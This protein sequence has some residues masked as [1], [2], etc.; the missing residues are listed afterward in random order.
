MLSFGGFLRQLVAQLQTHQIIPCVLRNYEGFP[1]TN[2]GNDVDFMIRPDQLPFAIQAVESIPG[3][4]IT[5]YNE[6]YHVAMTFLDGVSAV[7]GRNAFQVDFIRS[8]TWKGLP[9]LVPEDVIASAVQRNQDGFKF[10]VPSPVCEALISL[11]TSLVI[12][13]FVKERYFADVRRELAS[14]PAEAKAILR[15]AF[16][17]RVAARL[18]EATIDGDK[19]KILLCIGP[20]RR[21]L[22]IRRFLRK[23]LESLLAVI[24]HHAIVLRVRHS[25]QT[26][27]TI[28]I[29]CP[30]ARL[31][32][33]AADNLVA[34]LRYIAPEVE[35]G[36]G[37]DISSSFSIARIAC[38]LSA[39]WRRQFGGRKNL[40]LRVSSSE[41]LYQCGNA[42]GLKPAMHR[43]A[44]SLAVRFLPRTDL[45]IL[46]KPHTQ[47]DSLAICGEWMRSKKNCIEVDASDPASD[48]VA[49]M[50]VAVV[51]ALA[52][53]T[54]V[55]LVSILKRALLAKGI[56]SRESEL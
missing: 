28:R 40:T 46:L 32:K 42:K 8:F 25:P 33:Q 6:Q 51:D 53:R 19:S 16:G 37:L 22:L 38:W 47:T 4:R 11:L 44:A 20:L 30:N 21:A 1:E 29:F 31:G 54:E 43:W 23:P 9:Y 5:G 13:G 52:Q 48:V 50:R 7:P 2:I 27:Q 12:S 3:I 39:E 55:K 35:Y 45:W 18:V 41:L 17:Q 34:A 14:H 26:L 24:R 36:A 15:P 49:N 56:A 10:F